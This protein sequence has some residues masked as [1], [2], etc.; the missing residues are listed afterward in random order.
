MTGNL[1]RSEVIEAQSERNVFGTTLVL[2]PGLSVYVVFACC[3]ALAVLALLFFGQYSPKDTVRGYIAATEADVKVFAHSGGTIEE[4]FVSD[5]DRVAAGQPLLRLGTSR[6][7]AQSPG[8][9]EAILAALRAEQR[10]LAAEIDS[11]REA[12]AARKAAYHDEQRLLER[13][14]ALLGEQRDTQL[15][16]VEIAER[17]LG[18]LARIEPA[19]FVSA[20]DVDSAR[21]RLVEARLRLSAVE[22]DSDEVRTAMRRNA[23]ALSEHPH[24]LRRRTAEKEAEHQRLAARIAGA[25][26]V[27][28]QTVTAPSAG[29]VT[30]LLVRGGQTVSASRPL[31][32]LVPAEG[33]FYA[34]LLI[35]TRS[36]GV[37]RP[38]ARVLVRYDAFPHQKF[39][40]YDGVVE[41]VARTTTL[42]G[43]KSFP[44]PVTEAVYLARVSGLRQSVPD[45]RAGQPLQ[46]G[47]TLTADIQRDRRRIIEWLFEPLIS[48]GRR[49]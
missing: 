43:D 2:P 1:F 25:L 5:G 16:A 3:L 37:I 7:A 32:S 21:A 15:E 47:M 28:A 46:S 31:L 11:I 26:A 19:T 8:T 10:S 39:G 12:F 38:G 42:P 36:I 48:A 30:G 44:L 9:S 49:L 33:Q 24:L 40:V 35:P 4:I 22:L 13:R 17:A 6:R 18:R 20:G 27:S 29:I 34:E 23:A 14:L 41:Y 45:A